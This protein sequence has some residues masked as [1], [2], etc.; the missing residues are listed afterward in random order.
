M[1]DKGTGSKE[2]R[3]KTPSSGQLRSYIAPG[4][5]ATRTPCDGTEPEL[6]VEF[7]FTPRWYHDRLGID[8]SERWHLDPIYRHEC[9]VGMRREL[10]RRF[11]A[12]RLG[13]D[14]DATRANLDGVHGALTVAMVYGI[15]AAYYPDNW[16]AATHAYLSEK[17]IAAITPPSLSDSLVMAQLLSLIHISEPTRPY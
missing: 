10:N 17:E 5:P 12:L 6:R 15:P 11:P 13:G 9:V 3:R 2:E 16:P 14:P 4:A 7:G 8:F 1:N